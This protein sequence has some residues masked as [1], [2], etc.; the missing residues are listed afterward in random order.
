MHYGI[1]ANWLLER[2]MSKLYSETYADHM[3]IMLMNI[4]EVDGKIENLIVP[5]EPEFTG[6]GKLVLF[7]KCMSFARPS[8]VIFLG[9]CFA[10]EVILRRTKVQ[11]ISLVS[12]SIAVQLSFLWSGYIFLLPLCNSPF[13]DAL[14][15]YQRKLDDSI[16]NGMC[17]YIPDWLSHRSANL[18]L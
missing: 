5:K 3:Q 9:L 14:D 16:S 7:K 2:G 11:M 18:I 1:C 12:Q 10:T 8:Q 13:Q 17:Q 15:I 4:N 6:L